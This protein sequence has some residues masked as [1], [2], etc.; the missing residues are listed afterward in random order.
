MIRIVRAVV[1]LVAADLVGQAITDAPAYAQDQSCSYRMSAPEL[2]S[3]AA[4]TVQVT[5]TLEPSHCVGEVEPTV[6]TVCLASD[7]GPETCA[8][9]YAWNRA[10]VFW[11][12]PQTTASY[13]A[14][15]R[16]CMVSGDPSNE[17]CNP[18]G[19]I[20]ATVQRSP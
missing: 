15:G 1:I 12:A 6:S 2:S 14:T 10:Q 13:T 3:T 9:A 5:A 7:S 16:G 4:G 11:A 8:L 18:I 20:R 19:P 17:V